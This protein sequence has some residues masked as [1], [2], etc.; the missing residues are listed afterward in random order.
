MAKR[1]RVLGPN[2]LIAVDDGEIKTESGFII[3]TS[4][5]REAA[6]LAR[7]EGILEQVGESAFDDLEPANRPKIGDKVATARYSG[8]T[9]GKYEDGKERRV[10]Q[11]TGVLAIILED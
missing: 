9:L 3:A 4:T 6:G 1:H 5:S 2:V 8:K 7:E 11:D 10:L